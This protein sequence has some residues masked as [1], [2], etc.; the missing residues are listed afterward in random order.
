M[1]HHGFVTLVKQSGCVSGAN[2]WLGEEI[3][4]YFPLLSQFCKKSSGKKLFRALESLCGSRRYL[5][6]RVWE[7]F[8]VEH[9]YLVVSQIDAFA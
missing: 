8:A 1:K 7:S 9:R 6:V 4:V 2:I 3:F 5:D